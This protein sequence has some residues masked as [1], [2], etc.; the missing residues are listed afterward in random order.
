LRTQGSKG[1]KVGPTLLRKAER[2]VSSFC[3]G[4]H[5][6]VDPSTAS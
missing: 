6:N 5:F 3:V 2:E 4:R 1:T